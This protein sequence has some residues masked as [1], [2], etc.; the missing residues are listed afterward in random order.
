MTFL[1]FVKFLLEVNIFN[2]GDVTFSMSEQK[3]PN[4][5]KNF[6]FTVEKHWCPAGAN[7]GGD[8]VVISEKSSDDRVEFSFD[9]DVYQ[10]IETVYT[11]QAAM[12]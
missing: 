8:S 9:E 6:V 10:N 11:E 5:M 4:S 1:T 12:I 3:Y 2:D 7:P